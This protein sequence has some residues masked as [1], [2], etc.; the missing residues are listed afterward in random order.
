MLDF[1]ALDNIPMKRAIKDFSEP[2]D[3]TAGNLAI[4]AEKPATEE[5]RAPQEQKYTAIDRVSQERAKL[6]EAYSFFA[7]NKRQAGELRSDIL[8]GIKRRE[9][10]LDLLLKAVE[11]ISL[12]TGDRALYSQCKADISNAYY[13]QPKE[14]L[15]RPEKQEGTEAKPDEEKRGKHAQKENKGHTDKPIPR[16]VHTLGG[17]VQE[18]VEELIE[19]QKQL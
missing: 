7:K 6:R 17:L 10:P 16:G 14:A 5:K 1:R 8:Q 9:D 13:K 4:Q 11:C 2:K 18:A 19:K 12:M 15:E 3:A